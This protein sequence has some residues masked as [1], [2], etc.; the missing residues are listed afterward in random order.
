MVYVPD[1]FVALPELGLEIPNADNPASVLNVNAAV[2]PHT[3]PLPMVKSITSI[4]AHLTT[5]CS[6][7]LGC[8]QVPKGAE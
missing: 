2:A 1:K 5:E 7:P 6:F 4:A 8:Q 3:F